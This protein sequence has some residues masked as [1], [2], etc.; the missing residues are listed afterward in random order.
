M[1]ATE[2]AR[3][4]TAISPRSTYWNGRGA[5][6][7]LA[8]L[9]I[10]RAAY[11]PC[12]IATGAHSRQ[13]SSVL[14]PVVGQVASDED[15]GVAG[16]REVRVYEDAPGAV[17]LCAGTRRQNAP[18]L[19]DGHA[20]GHSTVFVAIVSA[21]PSSSKGDCIALDA[22]DP[23]TCPDLNSKL[24]KRRS[25]LLRE[26]LRHGRQNPL[27]TV[28]NEDSGHLHSIARKL[29]RNVRCAISASAPASSMPVGPAPTMAK[30]SHA[31]RVVASGS[32]SAASVGTPIDLVFAI[33]RKGEEASEAW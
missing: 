30:V 13:R 22:R 23:N 9:A 16:N 25:R 27:R 15:I 8:R 1:F 19:R 7:C 11:A 6:T 26:R 33:T 24:N 17:G 28:Q 12:C 29:F 21:T 4:I 14:P 5:R 3:P 10:A 31:A 20:A 18:K 2:D 32:F